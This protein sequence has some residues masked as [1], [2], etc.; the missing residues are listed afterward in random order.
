MMSILYTVA[1][2]IDTYSLISKL[3]F[4]YHHIIVEGIKNP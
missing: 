2:E 4:K 3:F 1:L